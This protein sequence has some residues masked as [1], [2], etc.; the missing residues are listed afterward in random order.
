MLNNDKVRQGAL[1]LSA[2]ALITLAVNE[3]FSDHAYI[4]VKGDVPTIGFGETRGV[5][6]GDRTTPIDALKTLEKGLE[7]YENAVKSCVKVPLTQNEF[8]AYVDF[9]YNAGTTAF[10]NS[11]IVKYLNQ[12]RYEDACHELLKWNKFRGQVLPGLTKR[13]EQEFKTCMGETT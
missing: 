7:P 13:R 1:A 4:P 6:L 5:K 12:Q 10:C 2:T 3:G 9:T 11:T 8:D